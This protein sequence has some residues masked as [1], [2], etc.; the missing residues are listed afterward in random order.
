M[1]SRSS[2][3][4]GLRLLLTA[5]LLTA[6]SAPASAQQAEPDKLGLRPGAYALQLALPGALS[7]T[8]F[9]GAALSAKRHL[10]APTAIRFGLQITGRTTGGDADATTNASHVF[11]DGPDLE[12]RHDGELHLAETE[13]RELHL[14]LEAQYVAY[15]RR[16]RPVKPFFGAGP[17][18][19]YGWVG[20]DRNDVLTRTMRQ[21]ADREGREPVEEVE[22]QTI[23]EWSRRR[24]WTVGAV[25]VVGGEWFASGRI[26]FSAEYGVGAGY[27]RSWEEGA[28]VMRRE[29]TWSEFPEQE[30]VTRSA[31]ERASEEGGWRLW[32]RGVR[33]GLSLYL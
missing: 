24:S 4:L 30:S 12:E 32:S 9:Q 7:F 15:P 11:K 3:R 16:A 18:L 14:D 13:R 17:S 25:A 28:L 23:E 22:R 31:Q 2:V 19:S 6:C 29:T 10:A 27:V 1:S 33:V 8:S 5:V 20:E 21:R 26:S